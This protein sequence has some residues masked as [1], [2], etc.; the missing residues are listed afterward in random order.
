[1]RNRGIQ[2]VCTL[3]AAM[4]L[5]VAALLA[6]SA[7]RQHAEHKLGLGDELTGVLPAHAALLPAALGSFRG[8]M[9]DYL[10]YRA[11]RLQ[12]DGEFFEA[13]TLAQAISALLPGSPA[14]WQFHAWNM[15]YNISVAT[16]TP[17]ERWDW[18]SKGVRLL[19]DQ[20]IVANPRAI[21][22]YQE[23]SRIFQHKIGQR[24]DDMHWYYKQQLAHEWQ[25]LLGT[26]PD[27]LTDEQTIDAIRVIAEA[28]Q[29]LDTLRSEVSGV[30][31]LLV[32]LSELGYEPDERL[33]RGVGNVR[34]YRDSFSASLEA[35]P[36]GAEQYDSRLADVL[37]DPAY[38]EPW[39]RLLAHLRR[40]VLEDRYHMD[41]AFMLELMRPES[42]GSGGAGGYGYGPIDWR[43]PAAHALYWAELGARRAS[44]V[45]ELQEIDLINTRRM[46]VQATQEMA[47]FGRISYDPV[48]GRYHLMPDPRFFEAYE[49]AYLRAKESLEASA[50]NKGAR[51]TYDMGHENLLL[52]AVWTHYM[53][54]DQQKAA[55]YFLKARNLYRNW[56]GNVREGYLS[57][58]DLSLEDYVLQELR[59]E[60]GNRSM[61]ATLQMVDGLIT[62]ALIE[63]LAMG[64]LEVYG[65]WTKLA[66]Q[67]HETFQQEVGIET[68]AAEQHRMRLLPFDQLL[69]ETFVRYML[70][71]VI[72]IR[73][74]AMAWASAPLTLRRAAYDRVRQVVED[75]AVIAGLQPQR[76]LPPPPTEEQQPA[77]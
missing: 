12:E 35:N 72:D 9:V 27:V 31:D 43:L 36:A 2:F 69:D 17:Q 26:P 22:L 67:I 33:V 77:Q 20:G 11:N 14:V 4:C 25:Q 38:V 39:V 65:R 74:R 48:S 40:R 44:E 60:L 57:W 28:P 61:S 34:M 41:R 30:S 10:W 23:L 29:Q 49:K 21:L 16:Y 52:S 8:L 54:G 42:D 71:P 24:S 73:V 68:P 47:H 19:R 55:E 37:G 50:E 56:K 6:R 58:Y 1:M 45:R 15:A 66:Q 64:R 63:G 18:V 62:R 13:N 76:V 7:E 46:A 51:S 32:R 5:C 75:Q 53:Y 70:S 59:N 3:T